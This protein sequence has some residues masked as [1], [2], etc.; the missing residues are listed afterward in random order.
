M[1]GPQE[2][3]YFFPFLMRSSRC[4]DSTDSFDTFPLSLSL[5][6]PSWSLLLASL[7]NILYLHRTYKC[8]FFSLGPTSV[9]SCVGVHRRMSLMSISLLSEQ[10]PACLAHFTWLIWEIRGKWL[11]SCCFEGTASRICSKLHTALSCSFHLAFFPG[12][13][14][15]SKWCNHTVVLIWLQLRR[16]TWNIERWFFGSVNTHACMYI[17]VW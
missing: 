2:Y 1:W 11:Y 4:A 15:Q 9:C 5:F 12:I 16:I 3:R 13:L 10:W 6:C 17:Y 8:K 14:L 7:D